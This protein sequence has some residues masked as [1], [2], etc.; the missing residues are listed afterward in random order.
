MTR[1]NYSPEFIIQVVYN[2]N[3]YKPNINN[4]RQN[5]ANPKT[6]TTK[7]KTHNRH[8]L[9]GWVNSLL[10]TNGSIGVRCARIL[11]KICWQIKWSCFLFW[12]YFLDNLHL[13]TLLAVV[14]LGFLACLCVA[15]R[16][17][18]R[19]CLLY[20][21]FVGDKRLSIFKRFH[22]QGKEVFGLQSVSTMGWI[23]FGSYLL[24]FLFFSTV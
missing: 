24:Y 11:I 18:R 1:T 17:L 7:Q 5:P 2:R 22:M 16:F 3:S 8:A 20:V 14:F 15:L 19:I 21:I 12:N 6:A 10:N 9:Y 13:R 23:V 4:K